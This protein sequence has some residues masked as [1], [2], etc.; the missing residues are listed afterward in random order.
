MIRHLVDKMFAAEPDGYFEMIFFVLSNRVTFSIWKVEKIDVNCLRNFK[1]IQMI[2]FYSKY[3][4]LDSFIFPWICHSAY[5]TLQF[6]WWKLMR[7]IIFCVLTVPIAN[8]Y[9]IRFKTGEMFWIAFTNTSDTKKLFLFENLFIIL[10]QSI[11]YHTIKR[12][13]KIN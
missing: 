7:A 3:C 1:I 11:L 13:N 5:I 8:L 6:Y 2:D 4:S 12:C 10:N 9:T